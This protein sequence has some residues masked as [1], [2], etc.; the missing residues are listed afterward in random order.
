MLVLGVFVIFMGII[1][2]GFVK[3]VVSV[4]LREMELFFGV[5]DIVL[6]C[7]WYG[8]CGLVGEVFVG[9][10]VFVSVGSGG[11]VF[12]LKIVDMCEVI[13]FIVVL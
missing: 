12:V 11:G 7:M 6:M 2:C 13:V 1:N 8:V 10:V 5:L 4:F 9:L 3:I